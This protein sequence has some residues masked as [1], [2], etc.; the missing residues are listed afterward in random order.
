MRRL[1]IACAAVLAAPFLA[2]VLLFPLRDARAEVFH[3]G[4]VLAPGDFALG[5]EGESQFEPGTNNLVF[6]HLGV[7]LPQNIDLGLKVSFF[8]RATYFGADVQYGLL[9]DGEGFPAL[10]VKGGGHWYDYPEK[11]RQAD[12]FGFDG[13]AIMSED[14]RQVTGFI[15]YDVDVDFPPGYGRPLYR[16]HVV[17]GVR[18]NVSEH[19]SFFVEGGY[20]LKNRTDP[21]R[22]YIS[23]GPTLFF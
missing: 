15:G 19:L 3:D 1:R 5:F 14:I 13:A 17:V 9:D 22:H 18:L 12:F 10:S 7:G 21:T 4:Q 2:T 11:T 16:Q 8:D 6:A 23:G 20:G